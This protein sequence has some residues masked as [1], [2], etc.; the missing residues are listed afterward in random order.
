MNETRFSDESLRRIAEQKVNFRYT[1]KIHITIFLIANSLLFISNYIFS[2]NFLWIVYPFFGWLI[3]VNLHIVAY[4]LYARGVYPQV[5]RSIIVHF[6][7]YISVILFLFI[8]NYIPEGEIN[9]ALIPA[10]FWGVGLLTHL[11]VYLLYFR[12]DI[13]GKEKIVSR[14]E[15]AIEKELQKM[16]IKMKK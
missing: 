6:V 15:R 9:W 3:G 14:K 16:K 10:I 8:I 2:P 11:F 1:V 7:A 12:K 5:K 4:L 13:E